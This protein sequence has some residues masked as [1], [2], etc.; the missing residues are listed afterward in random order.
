MTIAAIVGEVDISNVDRVAASL[1]SVSNLALGLVVDLRRVDY[2]D[3]A[4]ISLLH[5]LA[6]RLRERSQRLI[7][8]S[9]PDTPP[10]HVLEITA[11]TART[12]VLDELGPAIDAMRGSSDD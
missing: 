11:L 8:V 10:R 12:L 9:P 1:T 3:S 6:M 4:A 7:V 2:L 5:D